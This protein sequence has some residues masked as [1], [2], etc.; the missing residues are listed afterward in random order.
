MRSSLTALPIRQFLSQLDKRAQQG[1]PWARDL[2]LKMN[3]IVLDKHTTQRTGS[4]GTDMLGPVTVSIKRAPFLACRAIMHR[5][6]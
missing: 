4:S 1:C 2:Q 6:C 3:V 5:P